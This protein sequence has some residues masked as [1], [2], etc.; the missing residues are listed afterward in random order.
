MLGLPYSCICFGILVLLVKYNFLLVQS[1][2][3]IQFSMVYSFSY[4]G[5]SLQPSHPNS[6]HHQNGCDHNNRYN[7]IKITMIRFNIRIIVISHK[8][9]IIMIIII[10]T[11]QHQ[12]HSSFIII[13]N[14]I[15]IHIHIN[16]HIKL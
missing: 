6:P 4:L 11:H 8:I 10:V 5:R 1:A 9:T 2:G 3:N 13:I 7:Q 16:I 15:N 14:I 12:H